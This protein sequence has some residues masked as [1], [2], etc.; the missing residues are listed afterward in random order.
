MKRKLTTLTIITA[1]AV[2]LLLPGC[3]GEGTDA[4]ADQTSQEESNPVFPVEVAE[5]EKGVLSSEASISGT[6]M[7]AKHMPVISMLTGEV[8][9]VHVKN[10]DTVEKGDKLIEID[11]KDMELNLSQARAGLQ[12][13]EANFNS[14]KAM[15]EQGI[16]QAELQLKQAENM[17]EALEDVVNGNGT[18]DAFDLDTEN[19][20]EELREIFTRILLSNSNMPTERDLAQAETAVKQARMAL[21]QAQSTAQLEAAEASVT[22][23]ELA[24][25]MAESQK[26]NAVVTAPMSG[27]ITNFNM[28]VGELASPQ[29]PIMQLVQMDEPLVR[30]D[31]NESMLP[32]LTVGQD[33][34]IHLPSFNKMYEGF[35]KHISIMPGEQSR[36]YPVEITITNPDDDLR[37]GMHARAI[38]HTDV[39]EEQVLV[40]VRAVMDENGEK[41]VYVTF[42]GEQVERREIMIGNETSEYY[43]VVGGLVEGEFIVV[44]GTHQLYDGAHINVRNGDEVGFSN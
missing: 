31:V 34:D 23:A 2:M 28:V 35:V 10:G 40:P 26:T 8:V 4:Q 15:R 38:I 11:A 18:D 9:K 43:E 19:I 3:N 22:Q 13:A 24:V 32:N 37:I 17:H 44:R 7:A 42:D 25:E 36:S 39:T 12:A 29:V 1:A 30:I 6:V 27:Q 33:I 5:V 20:P 16:K 14:A 41:Y 21:E